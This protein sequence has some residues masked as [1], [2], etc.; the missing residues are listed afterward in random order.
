MA[1]DLINERT[2]EAMATTLL[3]R[4][5]WMLRKVD[6]LRL[7]EGSVGRRR[8]SLDILPPASPAL[9]Y[10]ESERDS[11]NITSV[12]GPVMVPLSMMRKGALRDFD[13]HLGDGRSLGVLQREENAALVTAAVLWE[14][15]PDAFANDDLV[16]SVFAIS[17]RDPSDA[18]EIFTELESRGSFEGRE[19]MDPTQLSE[20]GSQL[21]RDIVD[22]FLLVA[23]VPAEYAGARVLVKY[24]F[25]WDVAD[26]SARV[27]LKDHLAAA[28]GYA[29]ASVDIEL[30]GP[31]DPS[32]YHLEVHAP[33]GLLCQ[34][35]QLPAAREVENSGVTEASSS[36]AHVVGGFAQPPSEPAQV[37]FV[38]PPGGIR[39]VAAL[40]ATVTALVFI[41]ERV[42]PGGHRALLAAPEG[43][44][45]LLLAVPA[46][47]VALLAR[48]G[49]NDL[50]AK[51]L[52]PLRAIVVACSLALVAGA[53]SLVGYLHEPYMAMLW[54]SGAAF[55]SAAAAYILGGYVVS[56]V[57]QTRGRREK[58]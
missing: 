8:L 14:I 17:S 9:A 31:S 16:H 21:L 7:M 15:G 58:R 53:A 34:R 26:W 32:S 22:D 12:G 3:N 40:V 19:I 2:G 10:Y 28:A 29:P 24:S 49:E 4:S 41:L 18:R 23:L 5:D 50:A 36:V 38:V 39:T 11:A 13:V 42:L 43:A 54:W 48:S 55:T 56:G 20:F 51:L 45:A 46:V 37:Q 27:G 1:G 35:L 44:V 6:S 25:H 47:A 57:R 52:A 33:A 30:S